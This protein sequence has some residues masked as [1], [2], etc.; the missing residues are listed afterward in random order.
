[1][2][3]YVS[4]VISAPWFVPTTMVVGGIEVGDTITG[5]IITITILTTIIEVI[6]IVNLKTNIHQNI[7]VLVILDLPNK[8]EQHQ[9]Q[10]IRQNLLQLQKQIEEKHIRHHQELII[11]QILIKQHL[12]IHQK[13]INLDLIRHIKLILQQNQRDIQNQHIKLIPLHLNLKVMVLTD[14]Q[15]QL[16]RKALQRREQ[17]IKKQHLLDLHQVV[18]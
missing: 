2:V 3:K 1:V 12:S 18:K 17:H 6:T 14:H 7:I 11:N 8:V 10:G 4:P 16:I 15:H 13:H 5:V 9:D